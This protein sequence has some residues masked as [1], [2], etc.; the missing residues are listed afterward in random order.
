MEPLTIGVIITSL[1]SLMK[2]WVGYDIEKRKLAE[3][4][5]PEPEKPAKADEGKEIAEVVKTGIEKYG[6]E[7]EKG[8]L[9]NFQRNPERYAELMGQVLSDIAGRQQ[10]FEGQLQELAKKHNG[11]K[12]GETYGVVNIVRDSYGQS[13]GVSYGTMIQQGSPPQKKGQ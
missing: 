12:S 1:V 7:D 10:D 13:V 2:V 8:D 11:G 3:E 5:K 6:N 4:E 9:E